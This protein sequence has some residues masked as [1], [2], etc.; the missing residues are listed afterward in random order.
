[1]VVDGEGGV[2]G[3]LGQRFDSHSTPLWLSERE[4]ESDSSAAEERA[5]R[6]RWR[7][8]IS[9]LRDFLF[10]GFCFNTLWPQPMVVGVAGGD[11][12]CLTTGSTWVSCFL[13]AELWSKATSPIQHAVRCVS[14]KKQH[15]AAVSG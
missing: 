13:V 4:R 1:M 2:N 8:F 9:T 7:T 15:L 5:R 14:E 10:Y 6:W 11:W 12:P 3:V